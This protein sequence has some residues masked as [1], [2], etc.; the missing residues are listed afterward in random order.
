MTFRDRFILA[1]AS[2]CYAGY[3]PFVPGTFG[4]LAGLLL[5]YFVKGNPAVFMA[6]TL[7][8]VVIGLWVSGQAERILKDK[9]AKCIVI[10]EVSGMLISLLF[11]PYDVKV[12]LLAFF[13]FRVLDTLKPFPAGR[14]QD[15]KGGLGVMADD[16]VAGVYTNIILQV[17]LR[18]VSFKAS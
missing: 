3:L 12:V 4:S 7:F 8:C 13:L 6:G 18:L 11:L 16:V 15:L 9:D 2:S 10:D 1:L 17:A 14:I 5:Y